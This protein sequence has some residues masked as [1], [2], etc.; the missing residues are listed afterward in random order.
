MEDSSKI[1]IMIKPASANCNLR[2][3]YCYYYRNS[4]IY[5]TDHSHRMRAPTVDKIIKEYLQVPGRHKLISWQG[6]EPLL[7]GLDFFQK[8]IE[9]ERKYARP[10]Q[11]I[12]N[13][14]QTNGILIDEHWARFLAERHFLV[15]I[16]L[17]GPQPV[18]DYYRRDAAGCGTYAKVMRAIELLTRFGVD[19]NILTVV[20]QHTVDKPEDL[21]RFFRGKG[22][23]YLQFIPCAERSE[24]GYA[25]FSISAN[26]YGDF[27]CRL[28]DVY[29]EEDNPTVY[30]RTFDSVLHSFLHIEPPYCVFGDRCDTMITFEHNGEVFPCDFFVDKRWLLGNIESETLPDII[31]GKQLAKFGAATKMKPAQC[32]QCHWDFTCVGGCARYRQMAGGDFAAK[33]YFCDS[34]R[35]FFEHSFDK[36][37]ALMENYP[38]NG[39]RVAAVLHDKQHQLNQ[40]LQKSSPIRSKPAP[41]KIGR[42]DP[43]PCGSGLKYK[44]CCGK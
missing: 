33:N 32:S 43:C 7:A 27:L 14:L 34:W 12:E 23:F 30:E 13:N 35:T 37:K 8:A 16:S 11:V 41:T 36:L 17:D 29:L 42:N 3:E 24:E 6:G 40:L 1:S 25:D 38:A 4:S 19:F 18:H 21:Y 39:S 20:A 22:F 15:G 28:F 2:C 31:N 26:E 5:D 44:K 10:H 9:Y